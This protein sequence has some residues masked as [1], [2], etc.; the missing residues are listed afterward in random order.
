MQHINKMQQT[1]PTGVSSR[2][3]YLVKFTTQIK[4]HE[5][6]INKPHD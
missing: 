4:H 3:S 1:T 5:V 2:S 6:Q